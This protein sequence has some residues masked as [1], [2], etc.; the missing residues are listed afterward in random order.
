[1]SQREKNASVSGETQVTARLFPFQMVSVRLGEIH[2]AVHKTD[3]DKEEGTAAEEP[4]RIVILSDED[5]NY[6]EFDLAL[7]FEIQSEISEGEAI[8][9][10]SVM[11]EGHFEALVD[12]ETIDRGVIH[13]FKES[14]VITLLWPYMRE[15][16]HNITDRMG[17]G[18][19]PLPIVDAR[20]LISTDTEE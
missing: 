6:E 9:S 4:L 10:L 16:V 13:R 17:L 11:I 8:L 12:P 1:M 2:A 15:T 14:E 19:P 3:T 20:H 5:E 18:F 7:V